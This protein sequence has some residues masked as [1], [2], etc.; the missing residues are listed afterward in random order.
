MLAAVLFVAACNT[1]TKTDTVKAD[2]ITVANF[3]DAAD[4][5]IGKSINVKGTVV[6]TCKHGGRKMFIMG[7]T[8][9]QRLKITAAED[10]TP[11]EQTIEGSDVVVTGTVEELRIDEAYLANWEAE[12]AEGGEEAH[13]ETGDGTGDGTHAN[14]KDHAS[15]SGDKA[16]QGTHTAD[17]QQ[18]AAY[19]A[20]IAETEKGYL[21]FFSVAYDEFAVV[22]ADEKKPCC[23][24][25][26]D[27]DCESNKDED[28]K[29]DCDTKKEGT[30]TDHAH[31]HTDSDHKH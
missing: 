23:D 29:K 14:E 19:R 16:D 11:F 27:P 15:E 1:E 31:D 28:A 25:K 21:S 9:E 12:V 8:E 10:K 2:V 24:T 4:T 30:G 6:H 13:K 22:E 7:E 18:I 3:L 5:F 20:Q 26:K 17:L